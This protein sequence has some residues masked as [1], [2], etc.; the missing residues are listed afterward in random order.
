MFF[1]NNF[2]RRDRKG[3]LDRVPS[4]MLWYCDRWAVSARAF[5]T[6]TT[7]TCGQAVWAGAPLPPDA[8]W[9]PSLRPICRFLR[10]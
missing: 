2:R 10:A 7:H 6:N 5:T 1:G 9:R 4:R 3:R 8:P